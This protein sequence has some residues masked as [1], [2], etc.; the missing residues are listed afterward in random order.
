[1]SHYANLE[2]KHLKSIVA[3]SDEGTF[4]AAVLS[5]PVAQFALSRK[6]SVHED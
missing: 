2:F 6:I 1:M 4:T 5:L 3:S